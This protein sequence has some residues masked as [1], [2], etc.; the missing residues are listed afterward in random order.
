[1]IWHNMYIIGIET[2]QRSI[3]N[4]T[5]VIYGIKT[6][7]D[8]LVDHMHYLFSPFWLLTPY[9]NNP[10]PLRSSS[11]LLRLFS[12][13]LPEPLSL[14][15]TVYLTPASTSIP[16]SQIH[17]SHSFSLFL[18][19]YL[20]LT[21]PSLPP[22]L[23]PSNPPAP[24]PTQGRYQAFCIRYR[25]PLCLSTARPGRRVQGTCVQ[26]VCSVYGQYVC[27]VRVCTVCTYSACVV[28]VQYSEHF[29]MG[30]FIVCYFL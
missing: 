22:L 14:P 15:H 1:M 19:L 6:V 17:S 10:F 26:Y 20:A 29:Y 7:I 12:I 27:E 13:W 25:S 23:S 18:P 16:F 30:C 4:V 24:S 11:I 3:C 5:L 2:Y 8:C 21:L 28:Y 9:L